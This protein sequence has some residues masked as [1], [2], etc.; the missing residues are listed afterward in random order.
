MAQTAEER[1]ARQKAW[2]ELHKDELREKKRVYIR[3]RRAADPEWRK[4]VANASYY[5]R[6]DKPGFREKARERHLRYKYGSD[7][8]AYDVLLNRQNSV[9]GICAQPETAVRNGRVKKLAIDHDHRTK[10]IRGLLCQHCNTLLR[11]AMETPGWL[12]KAFDYLA[13]SA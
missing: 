5:R 2:R 13:R 6:R 7:S 9:C 10:K 8:T 11:Q 1:K 3:D 4:R 12:T